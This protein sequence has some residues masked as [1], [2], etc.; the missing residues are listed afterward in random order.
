MMLHTFFVFS[1]N[2]DNPLFQRVEN[3]KDR[4]RVFKKLKPAN[5]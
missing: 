2:P 5:V 3:A 1:E 4:K